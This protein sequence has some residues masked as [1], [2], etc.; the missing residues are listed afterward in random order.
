MVAPGGVLVYAVCSLQPEEGPGVA[1]SFLK[2]GAPFERIDA[3][4]PGATA[5][6]IDGAFLTGDGALRT[7]PCHLGEFGGMDGFYAIAFRRR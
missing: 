5:P 3:R 1:E 2:S 4:A 6:E 7:L